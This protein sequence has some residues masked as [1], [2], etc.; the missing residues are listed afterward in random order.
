[1]PENISDVLLSR[2]TA[3]LAAEMGLHLTRDRWLGVRPTEEW[4]R[5]FLAPSSTPEQFEQ[6]A[7]Q[8]TVGETYF[9]RDRETFD[10][11]ENQILPA[12]I[13]ARGDTSR[14][15]RIWSAGCCTG[16]EAYSLAILIRRLIPD[17]KDW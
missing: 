10:L 6:F 17:L 11:L 14:R 4:T 5:A 13:R 9:F 16:E 12:I 3:R 7:R 15:L 1:M 2:L 8:F